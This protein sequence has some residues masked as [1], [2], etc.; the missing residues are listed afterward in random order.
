MSKE[1]EKS[2]IDHFN[3][4]TTEVCEWKKKMDERT[5][6]A[7]PSDYCQNGPSRSFS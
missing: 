2:N 1:S 3:S 7:H 4:F 5:C 6:P